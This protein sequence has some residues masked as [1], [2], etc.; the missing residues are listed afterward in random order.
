MRGD[1]W[2]L[3][4]QWGKVCYS[5][6]CCI[7]VGVVVHEVLRFLSLRIENVF[8]CLV[9]AFVPICLYMYIYIYIY[10][11]IYKY[12]YVCMYMYVCICMYVC[13]YIYIYIYIYSIIY[14]R[15]CSQRR[16]KLMWF[17]GLNKGRFENVKGTVCTYV[18]MSIYTSIGPDANRLIY[19]C[20][21]VY[22]YVCI[23]RC[24]QVGL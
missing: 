7:F 22:R 5:V 8:R 3:V 20:M 24:I 15:D 11:Y 4:V 12:M 18:C 17:L 10:I 16:I 9:M 19:L 2:H 13:M 14:S 6:F 23:C 21:Y 1:K